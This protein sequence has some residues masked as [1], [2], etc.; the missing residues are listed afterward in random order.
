M[1]GNVLVASDGPAG[2]VLGVAEVLQ[3]WC[4]MEGCVE[5]VVEARAM[6]DI[7]GRCATLLESAHARMS[8][9]TA[10]AAGETPA[11]PGT[12]RG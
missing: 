8:A 2:I 10:T 4:G 11:A 12:D 1:A 3:A 7:V 5:T 9:A 6:G